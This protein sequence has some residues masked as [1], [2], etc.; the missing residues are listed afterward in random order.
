VTG[1]SEILVS[2]GPSPLFGVSASFKR[3]IAELI[4]LA[5][6]SLGIAIARQTNAVWAGVAGVALTLIAPGIRWPWMRI[7]IFLLGVALSRPYWFF[8]S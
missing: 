8:L 7:L 2:M 3:Q 4:F 5:S 6:S 1:A